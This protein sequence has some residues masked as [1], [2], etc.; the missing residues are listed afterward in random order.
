MYDKSQTAR[1]PQ[2]TPDRLE[3]LKKM[4]WLCESC[5]SILGFLDTEN[6]IL[7]IKYK[8]LYAFIEGGKVTMICRSC[9]KINELTEKE[10]Q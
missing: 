8:D 5:K 6:T 4:A 10:R 2:Q 9:G 3:K 1:K 7:R